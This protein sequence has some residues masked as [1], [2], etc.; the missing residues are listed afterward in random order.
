[1][2]FSFSE[3]RSDLIISPQKKIDIFCFFHIEHS[4]S[5]PD[6]LWFSAICASLRMKHEVL[7]LEKDVRVFPGWD[8]SKRWVVGD[9][10]CW[11]APRALSSLQLFYTK[12]P[13]TYEFMKNRLSLS[14]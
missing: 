14:K 6:E 1:M 3:H 10:W 4:I 12:N 2:I 8:S 5:T 11:L 13:G 7:I 9:H